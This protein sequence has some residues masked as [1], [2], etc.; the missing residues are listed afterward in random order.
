MGDSSRETSDNDDSEGDDHLRSRLAKRIYSAKSRK[1][2]LSN[3]V[4]VS[5]GV[6]PNGSSHGLAHEDSLNGSA[7][8]SADDGD[9]EDSD[10]DEWADEFEKELV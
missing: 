6:S 5:A 1:S 3:T 8:E 4:V 2:L 10:L 7:M 9:A